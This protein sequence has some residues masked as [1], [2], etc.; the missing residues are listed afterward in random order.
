MPVRNA[1][2][3]RKMGKEELR[4]SRAHSETRGTGELET[5]IPWYQLRRGDFASKG[6]ASYVPSVL[7]DRHHEV[8]SALE[9]TALRCL[10]L[11]HPLDI[12]EQFPLQLDEVEAEFADQ[13]PDAQGTAV[14]ARKLG[15]RHPQFREG[16]LKILST[17]FLVSRRSEP[18]L[19]VHVKYTRDLEGV[20][21][22]E[23]RAIEAEYWLQRGVERCIFTEKDIDRTAKGNLILLQ[24]YDRRRPPVLSASLLR[25]VAEIGAVVP[26]NAALYGLSRSS[27]RA[28]PDLVDLVKYAVV[29]GRL[30]LDLSARSL[31]WSQVWPA[32]SVHPT[33]DAEDDVL[34][35]ELDGDTL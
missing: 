8:L 25:Q 23:L 9:R 28:Y 19:A 21:A 29:T 7:F 6:R 1:A 5:Y 30:V 18:C 3:P 33:L 14:I 20:R 10:Q 4:Q 12:R 15:I 2:Y 24:S 17:D 32:M 13:Y 35:L 31:S 34:K 11:M 22:T 16:D 27:G 26:M